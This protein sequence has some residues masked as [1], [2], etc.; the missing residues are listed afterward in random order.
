MLGGFSRGN[1]DYR[2]FRNRSDGRCN[3]RALDFCA[4]SSG[5]MRRRRRSGG[6]VIWEVRGGEGGVS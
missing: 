1:E 3:R 4:C 2:S 6:R 5:Q